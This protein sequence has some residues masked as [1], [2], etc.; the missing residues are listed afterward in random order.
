MSIHIEFKHNKN[1]N[2]KK[3][4]MKLSLLLYI[5]KDNLTLWTIGCESSG[6]F[7]SRF[8]KD[9]PINDKSYQN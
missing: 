1:W 8:L 5:S 2:K 4:S 7:L 6:N 9:S 3:I